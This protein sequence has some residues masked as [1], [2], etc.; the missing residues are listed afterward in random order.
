MFSINCDQKE[1]IEKH[2]PCNEA[3]QS[4]EIKIKIEYNSFGATMTHIYANQHFKK[5]L[6]TKF[7]KATIQLKNNQQ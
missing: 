5:H 2:K 6:Y 1:A 4:L 3:I 7:F